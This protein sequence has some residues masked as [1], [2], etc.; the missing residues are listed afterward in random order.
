MESWALCAKKKTDHLGFSLFSQLSLTGEDQGVSRCYFPHIMGVSN[1]I[2]AFKSVVCVVCLDLQC[3]RSRSAMHGIGI[4]IYGA[5][6][7]TQ[8]Y[9]CE[10]A[11]QQVLVCRLWELVIRGWGLC[12]CPFTSF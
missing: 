5:R 2:R 3:G 6:S 12:Y 10:L 11:F 7:Y 8:T 9:V 1:D 4:G